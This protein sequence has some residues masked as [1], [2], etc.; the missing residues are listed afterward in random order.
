MMLSPVLRAS[1]RDKK[2]VWGSLVLLALILGALLGPWLLQDVPGYS[3]GVQD[4]ALGATAPSWRHP[5]GT[6]FFGRDVAVRTL[7]GLRISLA[8]G[9]CAAGVAAVLGTLFGATAGFVGGTVDAVMMRA[10]DVLYALP[11]IFL[12]IILVTLLGK[13]MVLL[14]MALGLVGWLMTA[15]IVRGRVLALKEQEF[16]AA[17]TNLGASPA[18]IILRH[19]LPN[20]AGAVLMVFTLTVPSLIMEEAFLSFLGLG[21]QAPNASLGSL[22]SD[23]IETIVLFWWLLVFPAATLSLLLLA[24]NLVGDAVRAAADPKGLGQ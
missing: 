16:V 22:I 10:V 8:V 11:Y 5:F 4:L 1:W 2:F 13:S 7:M 14:F 17:L 12:V 6:D 20:T 24:L 21:V 23:G 15:R 9:L 3:P 19:L 18:R